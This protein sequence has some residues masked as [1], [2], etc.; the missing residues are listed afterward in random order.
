MIPQLIAKFPPFT[1]ALPWALPP[2]CICTY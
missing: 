2:V 1:K